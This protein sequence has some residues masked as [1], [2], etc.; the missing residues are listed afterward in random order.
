VSRD[1]D[2]P[3]SQNEAGAEWPHHEL[4]DALAELLVGIYQHK[5][6]EAAEPA[7][8]EV[9][10]TSGMKVKSNEESCC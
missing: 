7:A 8:A 9:Q 1:D 4:A 5:Q 10:T 6:T 3:E 2:E